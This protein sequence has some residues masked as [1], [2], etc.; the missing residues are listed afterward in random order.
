MNNENFHLQIDDE[1]ENFDLSVNEETEN[2]NLSPDENVESFGLSPNDEDEEFTVEFG[3]IIN[4]G[5]THD[6]NELDNKPQINGNTLEGNKTLDELGIQPKGDYLT[7]ETD[8]TV[9]S[10]VKSITQE[11]INNWN[12]PSFTGD[13]EELSN[14][15]QINNVELIGNKS[16]SSL[17]IQPAGNY[18]T[19]ETDPTVPSYVKSITQNDIT[20]WNNKADESDI[21]DVSNFATKTELNNETTNRENT[22][23]GLQEQ[24]DAITSSSDVKDIVGTYTELQNYDTSTLGNDDII[25]VL[26]DSTHNEAMTYYRWVISG[27]TG[28]WQYVGQEGPYYTKSETET[29]LNNKQDEITSSNKLLSDLV[30]DTNQ[31]NKFVTENE[32]TTWNTEIENLHEEDDLLKR[33]LQTTTGSGKEVTLNKTAE[34][35][36][37]KPPLPRGNTEQDTTTGKNLLNTIDANTTTTNGVTYYRNEGTHYLSGTN[38]KTD[39]VWILPNTQNNNLPIFEAGQ[40]YTMSFKGTLPNGI[41]AQ[42]NAVKTSTGTQYNL[43]TIRS[44]VPSATFTIGSDYARTAQL[45]IGVMPAATNVDCN[46]TI[47]IEKG[48]TATS[49]EPYTGGI[50]SPNPDYPQEVEVVTGN[51]EVTISNNDNSESKT[52]PVSLGDIELCKIGNYQDYLYKNNGKWYLHK[53][54]KKIL[55]NGTEYWSISN[56]VFYLASISDY[57][58]SSGKICLSDKYTAIN[59]TNVGTSA[60]TQN[61]SICFFITNTNPRLYIRDERFNNVNAFKA[62]LSENNVK[63]YYP[64]ATPTDTEITDATLISQLEEISKTLSYQGQTNITSNTIAMFDVEAYKDLKI[65]L[66]EKYVKPSTGIPKKDLA[67]AVQTSLGKADTAV[68]K[69]GGSATQTVSL[70]SGTGTTALAVKSRATSSYISFSNSSVWIGSYGVSSDKKPVFYNGAGYTLAYTSDIPTKTSDLT[71]DSNFVSDASYVHTDNNYTTTEKSKLASL[72]NYDDTEIKSDIN[73]LDTNKQDI[74]DNNLQTTNK[75]ITSAINEVNSIAKGAN[76]AVGYNSYSDMIT[77]INA[78]DDNEYNIGQ[79]LYIV[80]VE[81]P[82]LWVSSVESTSSTYTY[83]DD[84]TVINDLNTN[85]YI[86]V[87]YYKL[88]MLETQK[89]DLTNYITNT[90]Y[91]SATNAGVIKAT[92]GNALATTAS[93]ELTGVSKNYVVYQASSDN[94]FISKGTLENVIT[95]KDLATKSDIKVYYG[96]CATG[97]STAAKVVVCENFTASDLVAGTRLVVHFTNANSYNGQATLNVNSTG[98]KNIYYNG[99]TTNA[100]YMWVAGESVEF[101]YNGEQWATINGG[102]ATTSYYGVTKLATGANSD[103]QAYALTPRSLYYF[104]NYSIAPYYSASKTYA[105]GDKVRYTYYIYECITAIDTPESWTA[106]HWQQVDP[107]QAQI[108]ALEARIRALENS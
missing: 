87:G 54:I 89:V 76:Q 84:A 39:S 100:R 66:D 77:A 32:K 43:G 83:V 72:Q 36:F 60:I 70:S 38:T 99:T 95:G 17:G 19:E 63:V 10:Y 8:P 107:L 7:E 98:A 47:Q 46:F 85:G 25:K 41:Y 23:H 71:N 67:S 105:V 49:Y 6:Y 86:Q 74:T 11:D 29:L 61:N 20:N 97:A 94:M 57:I 28:S 75:T 81:V 9:P 2:F 15:P 73:D 18:L 55:L 35:D 91:A 106:A 33:N 90:D 80:T 78:M 62:E 3:E 103:S 37:V 102:L 12:N 24:I 79:N 96:S 42:L 27:G 68:Q 30:N 31:T 50:P 5:G 53:E 92:A 40:T 88:S 59:N 44:T 56:N 26:Q 21:P 22:D 82:D 104:A 16:L 69:D 108:D 48:S 52:L 58:N 65:I 4:D 14:L 34:L 101:I 1:A 13:Y 64:T 93:G 51:V 45:F